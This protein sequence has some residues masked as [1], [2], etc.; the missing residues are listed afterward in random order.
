MNQILVVGK[1]NVGKTL[2]TLNF[3]SHVGMKSV[4]ITFRDAH[5]SHTKPFSIPDAIELFVST[6]EHQTK[7]LQSLLITLP[8]GKGTK[9]CE[10]IDSTG[11]VSHIHPDLPIR[12]AMGQTLRMVRQVHHM[13][14]IIDATQ[15]AQ[16]DELDRQLANYGSYLTSYAVIANKWDLVQSNSALADLRK[17]FPKQP[18]IPVSSLHKTGFKEVRAHVR[19]IL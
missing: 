4:Q 17:A 10:L 2:F 1:T 12:Q 8:W 6:T 14:H 5:T 18:V 11:L 9:Q 7:C 15:H 3:A 16:I 19:S 13:L